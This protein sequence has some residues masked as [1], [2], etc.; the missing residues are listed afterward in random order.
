MKLL[1]REIQYPNYNNI[2]TLNVHTERWWCDNFKVPVVLIAVSRQMDRYK[3]KDNI[4]LD[5][6]DTVNY[7]TNGVYTKDMMGEY[8]GS[9]IWISDSLPHNNFTIGSS[10]LP[11]IHS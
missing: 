1:Y 4:I 7:N 8:E 2:Q 9:C 11:L 6:Y 10:E 5:V 3:Q